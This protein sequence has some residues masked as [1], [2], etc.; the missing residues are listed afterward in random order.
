MKSPPHE[1]CVHTGNGRLPV[2]AAPDGTSEPSTRSSSHRLSFPQGW[3]L[4]PV[5]V[6]SLLV[7]LL[8]VDVLGERDL[9]GNI[10]RKT[11]TRVNQ[12]SL[13]TYLSLVGWN[14]RA[15]A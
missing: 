6:L 14:G 4:G 10:Q 1:A 13:G 15:A 11:D 12:L 7:F 5:L 3:I 2:E 9:K 8:E